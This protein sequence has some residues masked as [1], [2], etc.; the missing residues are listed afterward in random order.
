MK[1]LYDER[2]EQE[3]LRAKSIELCAVFWITALSLVIKS[4]FLALPIG[5]WVTEVIILLVVAALALWLEARKGLFDPYIKPSR[6][7]CLLI[8]LA[9]AV[10]LAA[11]QGAGMW[12]RYP[13][14]RDDPAVILACAGIFF[15]SIF[16]LTYAA[17]RMTARYAEGRRKKLEQEL[18]NGG[19]PED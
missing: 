12:Y 6:K 2:Q 19:E 8:S 7:N 3:S 15:V 9:A 4:Y 17:H 5:Y 11:A 13:Q 16:A 18:E 14:T 10:P 1:R